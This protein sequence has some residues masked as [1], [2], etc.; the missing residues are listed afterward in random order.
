[1]ASYKFLQNTDAYVHE[2]ESDL[3]VPILNVDGSVP[4]DNRHYQEYVQWLIDGN[5][6]L[7]ADPDPDDLTFTEIGGVSTELAIAYSIALGA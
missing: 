1:M 6:T 3:Y 2:T 7:P 5:S 4:I